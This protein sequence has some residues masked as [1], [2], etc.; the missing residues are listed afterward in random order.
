MV[1]TAENKEEASEKGS[2]GGPEGSE[3]GLLDLVGAEKSV[4][5]NFGEDGVGRGEGRFD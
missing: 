1:K 3:V 2:E 5:A 4:V